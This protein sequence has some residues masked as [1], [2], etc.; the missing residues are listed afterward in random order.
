MCIYI[1]IYI[2]LKITFCR[3]MLQINYTSVKKKE[4]KYHIQPGENQRKRKSWKKMLP[5]EEKA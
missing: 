5:I 4:K 2:K 1:Y 3:A